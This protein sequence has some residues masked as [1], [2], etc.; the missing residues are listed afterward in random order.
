MRIDSY[1]EKL[2]YDYNCVVIPGF[3]AFLAHST[4]AAIDATSNTLLPPSKSISFNAQLSKNDGL[5][6]S[7]IAKDKNL[8]Y[9]EML[10]EVEE[11]AQNWMNRLNQGET[12]ELFSIGKLW[13]NSEKRIQF[14][15]EN[16]I[17][18]LTSSF[19]LS[20]FAATPI[21]REVLKEEV[22]ELEEKIPFIITPEK[23]EETSFRP[24]LKYAAVILLAV[25]IGFTGY[26]TYDNH[27][28]KEF[29]AQQEAQT[30]VSK[31]IQEAT[32]FESAPLELPAINISVTKKQ[33]G[34]HHVIA[35]AFREENN[36]D[37]R[38]AQLKDKGYNAFYLGVNKYGLHQVA[39]DSFE[40]PKE[41]LAFLKEV[42][43]TESRDAWLLSEK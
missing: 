27:Q 9:E 28:K 32:F 23:R 26:N 36:A 43:T 17:N 25:S 6:V 3:G 30:E 35:G 29:A 18:F 10:Q 37:K 8:G 20:S 41:A 19:G 31:L 33:L 2:L 7:H 34:K 39:Y 21:H 13:Y 24:W 1:I 14:Q 5:L 38:V 11:V 22:V 40:D 42:K 12:V 16:R 4:S 15:P